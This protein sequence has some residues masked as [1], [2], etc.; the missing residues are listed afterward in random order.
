MMKNTPLSSHV[1]GTL[2]KCNIISFLASMFLSYN[3]IAFIHDKE[4]IYS[5]FKMKDCHVVFYFCDLG[6]NIQT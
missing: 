5:S 6:D 3:L 4:K 1:I 2:S